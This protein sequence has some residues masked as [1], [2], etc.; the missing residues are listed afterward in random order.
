MFDY[1]NM[2]CY[3][4]KCCP[5]KIITVFFECGCACKCICG[6][7]IGCEDDPCCCAKSIIVKDNCGKCVYIR[8]DKISSWFFNQPKCGCY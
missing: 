7:F 4:E 5:K 6:E 3:K 8:C 1:G 2:N